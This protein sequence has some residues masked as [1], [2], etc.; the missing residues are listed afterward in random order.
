MP[1]NKNENAV[2][3]RVRI[4]P[5]EIFLVAVFVVVA[6]G[7]SYFGSYTAQKLAYA[8][9]S[10]GYYS[11]AAVFA[12][13]VP[14]EG[15]TAETPDL[16]MTR[17]ITDALVG[18]ENVSVFFTSYFGQATRFIKQA[19]FSDAG[20]RMPLISGEFMTREQSVSA[21]PVCMVGISAHAIARSGSLSYLN[22]KTEDGVEYLVAD[23]MPY[24]IIGVVGL[25]TSGNTVNSLVF[26]NLGSQHI[27]ALMRHYFVIDA[28]TENEMLGAFDTVNAAF[29]EY[30]QVAHAT[31]PPV[32]E[33]SVA[34]FFAMDRLNLIMRIF[35]IFCL[36]LATV[37]LTLYWSRR[38]KKKVAVRRLLGSSVVAQGGMMIGRFLVI[39]HIGFLLGTAVYALAFTDSYRFDWA[40]FLQQTLWSYVAAMAVNLLICA[41]PF[42]Q[43]MLVEP[44]DALRR[45]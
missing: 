17:D 15:I 29:A 16:S 22:L 25:E 30:G 2:K 24:R 38:R 37:P 1:K 43:T 3:R 34:D 8:E 26:L 39:F 44:G 23:G 36:V 27:S 31:L 20:Y 14:P 45:E 41:V 4:K 35:S 10:R 9:A 28:P 33:F 40:S 13:S 18:Q 32:A 21:E 6:I 42:V 5:E 12:A 7:A 19:Y 11:E